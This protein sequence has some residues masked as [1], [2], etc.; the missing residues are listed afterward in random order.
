M[1]K[2]KGV[3]EVRINESEIERVDLPAGFKVPMSTYMYDNCFCEFTESQ[4]LTFNNYINAGSYF[5]QIMQFFAVL[6]AMLN[7]KT[8]MKDILFSSIG[9][10]VMF[11]LLWFWVRLYNIPFLS[12]FVCL[13]GN[14]I[15]RLNLHF[16]AIVAVALF[17]VKDWKVILFC[18]IGAVI[19]SVVRTLLFGRLSSVKYVDSVVKF[20]SEFRY[21]D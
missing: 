2:I 11:T 3:L 20:V 9:A 21:K 6:T 10:G 7:G 17:V 4:F 15:F 13:I 19:S 5:P 1:I 8:S 16:V 18:L 12:L 14:S